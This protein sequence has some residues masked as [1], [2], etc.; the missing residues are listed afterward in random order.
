MT[1]PSGRDD[2]REIL[3]AI[4][5]KVEQMVR[6]SLAARDRDREVGGVGRSDD[7]MIKAKADADG[8]IVSLT[9]DP[10]VMRRDAVRLAE[11][12]VAVLDAA[13]QD[14]RRQAREVLDGAGL[15][16]IT[17]DP[18]GESLAA[19]RDGRAVSGVLRSLLEMSGAD[20]GEHEDLRRMPDFL[21][22]KYDEL[23]SVA[24]TGTSASGHVTATADAH[25]RV[26][27]LGIG[28]RAMRLD[29]HVLAE[30]ILAAVRDARRAV[31]AEAEEK[32]S[33]AIPEPGSGAGDDVPRSDGSRGRR[34]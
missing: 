22:K 20:D 6:E 13:H 14:A 28:P 16:S 23:Q 34:R 10:R 7:G 9:L 2:D 27:E 12:V 8:A 3:A 30:D 18:L 1:T 5:G 19:D 4:N 21:E 24:G 33:G 15:A 11:D 32:V 25:G 29:S 17:S 31:V 26:R